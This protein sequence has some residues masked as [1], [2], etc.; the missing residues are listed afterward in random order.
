MKARELR[1]LEA[2]EK[3]FPT[4]PDK[5]DLA[6][7]TDDELHTW[8]AIMVKLCDSGDD[9]GVLTKEE[10]LFHREMLS[11]VSIVNPRGTQAASSRVRPIRTG[12]R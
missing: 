8:R 6:D 5:L 1:R 12:L 2:L 3:R 4:T 7:L 10:A 9:L 11:K